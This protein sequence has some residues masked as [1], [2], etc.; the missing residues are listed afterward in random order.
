MKKIKQPNQK[1]KYQTLPTTLL[2]LLETF[3]SDVDIS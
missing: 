3:L 1:V 2:I